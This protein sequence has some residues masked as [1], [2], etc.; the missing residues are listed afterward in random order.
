MS[1]FQRGLLWLPSFPVRIPDC[2][3]FKYLLHI[4]WLYLTFTAL[5]DCKLHKG[6]DPMS[7]VPI[8][9]Q[10][11]TVSGIKL[12][13]YKWLLNKIIYEVFKLAHGRTQENQAF[14]T[15]ASIMLECRESNAFFNLWGPQF[16]PFP[17]LFWWQMIRAV[18][19]VLLFFIAAPHQMATF[20]FISEP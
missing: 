12:V 4:I 10:H 14:M 13:F 7:F 1:P 3:L 17:S 6:R 16:F 5:L 18:S 19:S 11:W 8:Y 2:F 20:C 15:S 9:L